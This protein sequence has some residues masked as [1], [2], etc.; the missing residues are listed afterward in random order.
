MLI[1][2][3]YQNF[4]PNYRS[5][6]HIRGRFHICPIHKLGFLYFIK[7]GYEIRPYGKNLQFYPT[8]RGRKTC[9]QPK[10]VVRGKTRVPV[11]S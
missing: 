3:V 6:N 9:Q 4:A 2:L 8:E 5:F 7:G 10:S 1:Y 11:K